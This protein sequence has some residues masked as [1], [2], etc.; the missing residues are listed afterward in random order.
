MMP[1]EFLALRRKQPVDVDTS[2]KNGR[3]EYKH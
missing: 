2:E 1:P 3:E